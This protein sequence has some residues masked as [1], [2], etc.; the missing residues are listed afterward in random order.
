MISRR[1]RGDTFDSSAA[2]QDF[3]SNVTKVAVKSPIKSEEE[4][5]AIRVKLNALNKKPLDQI[6]CTIAQ[7]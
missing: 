2:P 7:M 4:L 3:S 6:K 1:K 5:E